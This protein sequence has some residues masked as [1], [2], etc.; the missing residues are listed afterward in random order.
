V[1]EEFENWAVTTAMGHKKWQD[2]QKPGVLKNIVLCGQSV[3]HDINFLRYSYRSEHIDWPFSFKNLDLYQ[4]SLFLFRILEANGK[5]VPKSLSLGA[6]AQYFGFER[7]ED[8]HNALEDSELTG[9]CLK[10]VLGYAEKL[11]L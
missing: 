6:V 9:K 5:P 2:D 3:Y 1:I 7:N 11:K 10:E 4:L 8:I